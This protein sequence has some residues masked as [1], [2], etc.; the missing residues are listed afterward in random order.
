MLT[1]SFSMA[2]AMAVALL[3]ASA[4][5]SQAGSMTLYQ[6]ENGGTLTTSDGKLTFSGFTA[7]PT[8]SPVPT[9][10]PSNFTVMTVGDGIIISG[11]L[12]SAA[13]SYADLTLS[14][15]V[16]ANGGAMIED[17]GLAVTGSLFGGNGIYSVGETL[18]NGTTLEVYSGSSGTDH[19]SFAAV[20]SLTAYKDIYVQGGTGSPGTP[21]NISLIGQS[22]SLSGSVPEPASMGL[23]GIGLAGLL[24]YRRR[25][26]KASV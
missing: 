15:T 7:G 3:A 4:S 25:F 6:L 14:Y 1:R 20:S 8:G 26:K 11:V 18:S 21:T 24:A 13:N 19:K 22:Y 5:T 10:N 12:G 17:A 16:A 2:F 9:F 23:L